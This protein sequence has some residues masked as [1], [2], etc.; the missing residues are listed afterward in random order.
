MACVSKEWRN[1]F[2]RVIEQ[3]KMAELAERLPFVDAKTHHCRFSPTYTVAIED[4]HLSIGHVLRFIDA[5]EDLIND[6]ILHPVLTS[7][8]SLKVP[9]APCVGNYTF[10]EFCVTCTLNFLL[11]MLEVY[12]EKY[13][14]N[15]LE[16]VNLVKF[17]T[18]DAVFFNIFLSYVIASHHLWPTMPKF[19]HFG[20]L[21]LMRVKDA[22][23]GLLN[24]CM[25]PVNDA[26]RRTCDEV[27]AMMDALGLK[28]APGNI[29]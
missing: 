26:L 15:R 28:Y 17:S 19:L 11:M 9:A 18:V 1:Y 7:N 25:H 24:N 8:D 27:V 10:D 20:E 4:V 6:G 13:K 22:R 29:Q 16:V 21:I 5:L 3:Q 2:C 14:N 23:E 12:N